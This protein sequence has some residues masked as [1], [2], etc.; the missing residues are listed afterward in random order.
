M[1]KTSAENIIAIFNTYDKVRWIDWIED[2]IELGYAY[3]EYRFQPD[4]EPLR[5]VMIYLKK[6]NIYT[7]AYEQAF[8]IVFEEYSKPSTLHPKIGRLLDVIPSFP[9]MVERN[10]KQVLSLFLRASP[11][12]KELEN[13]Q[14]L[15]SQLLLIISKMQLN[16]GD[17]EFQTIENHIFRNFRALIISDPGF[18]G[19]F[20]R[21]VYR[22]KDILS[23]FTWVRNLLRHVQ[24]DY[25]RE[26]LPASFLVTV[27][28]TMVES[29][30]YYTDFYDGFTGWLVRLEKY[31]HT[32]SII[33]RFLDVLDSQRRRLFRSQSAAGEDKILRE[34]LNEFFD[35]RASRSGEDITAPRLIKI[36]SFFQGREGVE[37][38]FSLLRKKKELFGDITLYDNFLSDSHGNYI[39]IQGPVHAI[40]ERSLFPVSFPQSFEYHPANP[41]EIERFR[42]DAVY[43]KSVRQKLGTDKTIDLEAELGLKN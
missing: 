41:E 27:A 40:I 10:K 31:D 42:K 20:L 15:L 25:R 3:P 24:E 37:T 19:N 1:E 16:D 38:I 8:A 9:V 6:N 12:L 2:I 34:M 13:G 5:D 26:L 39:E 35:I 43:R 30:H 4:G 11:I 22:H 17:H 33:D 18:M 36:V 14:S 32:L 28:E 21:F 29:S 23:Y 7:Q